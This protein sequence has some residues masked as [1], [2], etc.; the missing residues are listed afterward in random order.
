[1]HERT[2]VPDA[3]RNLHKMDEWLTLSLDVKV[4]GRTAGRVSAS[5]DLRQMGPNSQKDVAVVDIT[6]H[7]EWTRTSVP[8]KVDLVKNEAQI[9]SLFV[10]Y[11]RDCNQGTTVEWRNMKLEVGD[12]GSEWTPAPE[13][14]TTI[15]FSPDDFENATVNEGVAAGSSWEQLYYSQTTRIRTKQLVPLSG[16]FGMFVHPDYCA[17]LCEFGPNGYLGQSAGFMNWSN[18]WVYRKLNS[19]TTHVGICFRKADGS[20]ITPTEVTNVTGGGYSLMAIKAR[21]S[22][23][24]ENPSIGGRNL[25][26]GSETIPANIGRWYAGYALLSGTD[27]GHNYFQITIPAGATS[28]G[29]RGSYDSKYCHT[30]DVLVPGEIY[31]YSFWAWSDKAVGFRASSVGHMRC[32]NKNAPSNLHLE[33]YVQ[34]KP[35]SIPANTWTF[36]SITFTV[37]N[38]AYMLPYLW[39]LPADSTFRFS[40]PKVEK[41]TKATD[42]TPAPE[43]VDSAIS[44]LE[45]KTILNATALEQRLS[46]QILQTQEQIQQTVT[47]Q[48]F[49][50]DETNKLIQ[51]VSTAFTQT[52]EGWQMDFNKLVSIVN[53]NQATT[54]SEFQEWSKYIRFVDGNIILGA[55]ANPVVLT[56]KNDR[57]SFSQSGQE[58]AYLSNAELVVTDARITHGLIIGKFRFIPRANGSLDFKKVL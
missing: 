18:G 27:S 51:Q 49:T 3:S 44:D 13:E 17:C 35:S 34:V 29:I 56:I 37:S 22:V 11:C 16:H 7:T 41:G 43:D 50:K 6:D 9:G 40:N 25:L 48:Y 38:I 5:Y 52:A 57:I 12:T 54:D 33:S 46:S 15:G 4:S 55:V 31:T 26:I 8:V 30:E 1:M 24:I 36:C 19:Q 39:Y 2:S 21:A 10:I 23:E 53:A 45:D 58:V 47:E 20:A 14:V 28:T 32:I 42:W